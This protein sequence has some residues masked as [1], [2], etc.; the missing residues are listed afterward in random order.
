MT[1]PDPAVLVQNQ[2]FPPGPQPADAITLYE[3]ADKAKNGFT[4][5][6]AWDLR[7]PLLKLCWD[8]L[9]FQVPAKPNPDPTVPVGLRDSVNAI[10]FLSNQNNKILRKLAEVG[11]VDISEIVGP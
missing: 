4:P 1:A 11:K 6:R 2:L 9:R 3:G 10:L 7:G 8:L 5:W